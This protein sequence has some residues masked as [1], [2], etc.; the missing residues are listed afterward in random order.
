[1][2]MSG[3]PRFTLDRSFATNLVSDACLI[4][5]ETVGLWKKIVRGGFNQPFSISDSSLGG[6]QLLNLA[7]GLAINSSILVLDEA[8]SRHAEISKH[9]MDDVVDSRH[10]LLWTGKQKL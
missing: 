10:I 7:R 6:R 4:V 1:M 5:L 3:T 9:F 2:F 8:T